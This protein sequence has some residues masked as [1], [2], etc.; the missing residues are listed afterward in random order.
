MFR[1]QTL[2]LFNKNGEFLFF[3]EMQHK[4]KVRKVPPNDNNNNDNKLKN[5]PTK[6]DEYI[7]Q[8]FVYV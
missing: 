6:V 4:C 3:K 7:Y 2:L 8:R 5:K 1:S